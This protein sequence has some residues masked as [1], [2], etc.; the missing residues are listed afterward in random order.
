MPFE[1]AAFAL[2]PGEVSGIVETDIGFHLIKVV[3]KKTETSTGYGEARDKIARYL[4]QKQVQ[5]L[6]NEYAENIKRSAT[7]ERFIT[8]KLQ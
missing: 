8:P 7:I 3:D 2:E 1:T 4:K 6:A 5:K